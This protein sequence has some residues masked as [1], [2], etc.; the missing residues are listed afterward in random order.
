L[1][2]AYVQKWLKC[3]LLG[4]ALLIM[5]TM[6]SNLLELSREIGMLKA[7]ELTRQEIQRQLRPG[8]YF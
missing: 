3:R 1:G 8:Q 7:V 5:K 2:V 4:A 6:T